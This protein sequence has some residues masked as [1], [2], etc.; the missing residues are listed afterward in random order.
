MRANRTVEAWELSRV[1]GV[2]GKTIHELVHP[3]CVEPDCALLRLWKKAWWAAEQGQM[4]E[5][6][7][8]DGPKDRYLF[9]QIRPVMAPI[10]QRERQ[11]DS[12]ATVVIHDITERKLVEMA[13]QKM[14]EEKDAAYKQVQ[15]YAHD[16]KSEVAER[17]RAEEVLRQYADELQARNEELD[18]FAHTVAHDLKNPLGPIIGYAR[19]A[20]EG[21]I[22]LNQ[23]EIDLI[24][25]SVLRNSLKMNSIIEALLLLA[26]VRNMDI[27]PVSVDM[28]KIMDETLAH[29]D[30]IISEYE[31]EII[32]PDSLA[33]RLRF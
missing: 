22:P 33:D 27:E 1:Q 24:L 10:V 15:V 8:E 3:D 2:K 5:F 31:P 17:E 13:L 25:R 28:S 18:A 29:L 9:W 21:E 4:A 16:L 23:E 32:L 30:S 14:L 12:F 20:V 19:I 6:E 11:D 7:T 26:G